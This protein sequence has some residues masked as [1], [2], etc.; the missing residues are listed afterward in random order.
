MTTR[1]PVDDPP[2]GQHG[3]R[4]SASGD[5]IVVAQRY[6]PADG[7][8]PITHCNLAHAGIEGTAIGAHYNMAT[9][10]PRWT[11]QG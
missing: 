4:T 1:F 10:S 2:G 8:T 9:F 3:P 6:F 11:S 5:L 7:A